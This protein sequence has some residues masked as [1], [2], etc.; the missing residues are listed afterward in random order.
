[1]SGSFI[2]VSGDKKNIYTCMRNISYLRNDPNYFFEKKKGQ[3]KRTLKSKK[4]NYVFT[5]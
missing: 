4:K 1:M 2:K 5:M 3:T